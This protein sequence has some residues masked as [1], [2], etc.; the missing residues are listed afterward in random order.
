MPRGGFSRLFSAAPLPARIWRFFK[1]RGHILVVD[2]KTPTPDEDSG[3]ASTFSYL[4]I[5]SRAG[6]DVTF[7]P[8]NLINAGRYTWALNDLGIKTLS[9][10]EWTS[11]NAVIEAFAP[12][13]DLLL[14]YRAPVAM[15]V[16]NLARSVAPA[17]KILFHAVD[18]HFLR[19]QR[20]AA[21]SGIQ[22]QADAASAVRA[23]ELDLIERADGS[24]VVS[25][26]EL[27]L[28]R[29]LLPTAVVHQIPIL[30]ET[31]PQL[32]GPAPSLQQ[33]CDF[34]FIGGYEHLPN[35]DAVQW[36]VSEVWPILLSRRFSHRFIIAGSKVPND[37]A[38]LASEK[39]EVRGYVEDLAPL[40][41]SCRLSVAPLRY[42]A[43]IKGKIVTSLSY[44]VPVV[45]TSIAAEGTDLRHDETILVADTPNAMAD[46]IMRLYDDAHLWQRLSANGYQAFQDKF[47]LTAGAHRVLAVVDGLVASARR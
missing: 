37:I 5:L 41:A 23:I 30:R 21:L 6:F 38:A 20:E 29:E 28:L 31:P 35:V 16:F 15:H 8:F 4:Q 12:R 47:S 39:I 13:S 43:G 42:G 14:L 17:A 3:S 11:M 46:Q 36:F 2:L 1:S 44:G 7:A 18:L 24:I 45:A 33:R 22:A 26:Y 25:N 27:N 10:P 9:A 32:P 40:F 34:L 19:M